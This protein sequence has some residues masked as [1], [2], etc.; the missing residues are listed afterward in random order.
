MPRL[1]AYL[2]ALAA[3]LL[4]LGGHF[5]LIDRA[6]SPVPLH[7]QWQAEAEY[8]FLPSLKGTLNAHLLFHY[9][10]EHRIVP[11][12]L[13]ALALFKL[14]DDRWDVLLQMTFNA[15]LAAAFTASLVLLARRHLRPPALL[16]F[17]TAFGLLHASALF[18][19]NALWGFQSQFYFLLLFT[20]A[21]LAL[22][23]RHAPLSPPW[24]LGLACSAFAC[25]S[26]G[27]GFFSAA[28]VT[29]LALWRLLTARV[30]R[31]RRPALFNTLVHVA[32]V[33][34]ALTTAPHFP[35]SS[36]NLAHVLHTFLHCLAWPLRFYNPWGALL[37][38][39]FALFLLQLALRLRR[40]PPSRD[41]LL[42]AAGLWVLAQITAIAWARST[43][44][45]VIAPRYYDILLLGLAANAVAL[46]RLLHFSHRHFPRPAHL[47]LALAAALWIGI[48]AWFAFHFAESHRRYD[49]PALA[50]YAER[51]VHHVRTF[52]ATDD[53]A[54]LQLEPYPKTPHPD[55]AYLT[56]LLRD[57]RVRAFL[58]PQ[59]NDLPAPPLSR[60]ATR[61]RAA[62][63]PLLLTATLTLL[64]ATAL[65][66]RK[67]SPAP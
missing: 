10:S 4:V 51:Q 39:P 38:L 63:W 16:L 27:S 54:T 48:A 33:A 29:L 26:M 47:S 62:A 59:L 50:A 36:V 65:A 6:G 24:F 43:P 49:L 56:Q 3:F 22:V 12:R 23:L 1:P 7:D 58:P 30:L 35:S 15:A 37:W 53:P 44:A 13:L 41:L 9:H 8:V 46:A 17:A 42:A 67:T 34:A 64:T 32:I 60:L 55:P 66:R 25:L 14:N 18:Y 11:T 40:P 19:G 28:I 31:V 20:L 5:L 52:L 21:H 57:P 61:L 45:P 2:A